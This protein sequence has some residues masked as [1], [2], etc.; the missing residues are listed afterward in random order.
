MDI[1]I[2]KMSLEMYHSYAENFENDPDLCDGKSIYVP[3]I[4]T[5]EKA[6][7]YFK[8]QENMNRIFMAILSNNKIVGEII[9][10]GISKESVTLSITLQS[11]KYKD[12]GIGTEAE[13]LAVLYAFNNLNVNTV[14]ADTLIKNTRSQHVLEKVGFTEFKRDAKFIYYQMNK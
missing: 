11:S 5:K 1:K 6:D 12:Q 9:F 8:K 2:E 7:A 3:Y 14:Y 10:K 13:K 4:Y